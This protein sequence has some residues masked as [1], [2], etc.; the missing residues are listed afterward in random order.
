MAQTDI[1]HNLNDNADSATPKA[2]LGVV[3]HRSAKGT[4][5]A[6]ARASLG[7][8]TASKQLST[9]EVVRLGFSFFDSSKSSILVGS[10]VV[11]GDELDSV[12]QRE[13]SGKLLAGRELAGVVCMRDQAHIIKSSLRPNLSASIS[14]ADSSVSEAGSSVSGP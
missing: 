6:K 5:T 7:K 10:V 4:S 11:R 8:A 14:S 2:F 3:L 9:G 1:A 12:L 13:I